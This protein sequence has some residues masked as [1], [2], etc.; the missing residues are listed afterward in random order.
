MWLSDV[1]LQRI[2]RLTCLFRTN[3]DVSGER[4]FLMP[5]GDTTFDE[6]TVPLGQG[7]TSRG[8]GKEK[9][10]HPGAPRPLALGIPSSI[11]GSSFSRGSRI[12]RCHIR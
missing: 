10:A 3:E 2:I 8:F 12:P 11:E 6:N 5:L 4:S 7:G 9:P 1:A